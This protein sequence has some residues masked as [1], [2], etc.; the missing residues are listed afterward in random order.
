SPGG[1]CAVEARVESALL[2]NIFGPR[3]LQILGHVAIYDRVGHVADKSERRFAG[4]GGHP[5]NGVVHFDN[6]AMLIEVIGGCTK[7]KAVGG[8]DWLVGYNFDL[9]VRRIWLDDCALWILRAWCQHIIAWHLQRKLLRGWN[10]RLVRRP[11]RL[12]GSI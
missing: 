9:R 12:H 2:V 10:E 7:H 5:N 11:D 8:N 1:K 4:S 6:A 3:V